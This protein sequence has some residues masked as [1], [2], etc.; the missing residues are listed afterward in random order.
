MQFKISTAE[1]ELNLKLEDLLVQI[2]NQV[3]ESS[4]SD[5][6]KQVDIIIK[7]LDKMISSFDDLRLDSSL[8]QTLSIYF[9]AGYYYK[10]FMIKNNV[11]TES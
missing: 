4:D 10:I 2:L 11:T 1:G 9:L 7:S 6:S 5:L 3:F 8:K